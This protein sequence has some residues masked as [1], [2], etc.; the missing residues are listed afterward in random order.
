MFHDIPSQSRPFLSLKGGFGLCYTL[1]PPSAWWDTLAACL[2][3]R[4]SAAL[5][6]Y[7]PDVP[8][9]RIRRNAKDGAVAGSNPAG[10]AVLV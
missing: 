9:F 10:R 3:L 6:G 5:D 2:E 1:P 7:Y 8:G 4:Y